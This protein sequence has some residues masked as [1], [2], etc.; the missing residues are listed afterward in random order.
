VWQTKASLQP[1]EK[2]NKDY[3]GDKEEKRPITR[4]YYSLISLISQH[5]KVRK[6]SSRIFCASGAG[7]AW[8]KKGEE[9]RSA[10]LNASEG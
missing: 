5:R 6:N 7:I 4:S 8:E 2:S 1:T 9:G 10:E 3:S